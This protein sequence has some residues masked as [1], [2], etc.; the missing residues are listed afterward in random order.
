MASKEGL[1]PNV[2]GATPS[3]HEI[4]RGE[5]GY[6]GVS[7]RRLG[8]RER[9]LEDLVHDVFVVVHRQLDQYDPTRPI[10]PWL[11]GIAMRVALGYRRRAG[12]QLEIVRSAPD[13]VD[14]TPL[15]DEQLDAH[16]TREVVLRGLEEVPPDQRAVFVMHDI[17]GHAM[18][19]IVHALEIPLNTGYSRLRAARAEF[20]AAVRRIVAGRKGS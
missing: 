12:H 9:D 6:V 1:S 4:F 8:I 5:A 18:P 11:F 15:P 19:E 14:G 10:R 7:L 3:F 13:A 2:D 20:G 17:D 16:K